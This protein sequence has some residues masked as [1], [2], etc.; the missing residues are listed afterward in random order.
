MFFYSHN[1][2][3]ERILFLIF[4]GLSSR[5]ARFVKFVMAT[6]NDSATDHAPLD[7]AISK[8]ALKQDSEEITSESE[9]SAAFNPDTGE[10]N[11]D[12]P[13]LGGM[14]HGP[15]GEQFKAAFSCF[16][17][18]TEEPKGFDCVDFFKEMQKCFQEH[19]DVYA[20]ELKD[21]EEEELDE[22]MEDV[23]GDKTKDDNRSE[24]H[25]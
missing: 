11:W 8:D 10:I 23:W 2:T 22:I 6:I 12:C 1:N 21:D 9:Q 17:Y 14:A 15:C 16:V 4:F 5:E 19:P 20:E 18:S 24:Q 7:A 25:R 3:R 13:C